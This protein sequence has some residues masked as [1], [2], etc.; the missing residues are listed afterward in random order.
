MEKKI[1]DFITD[2]FVCSCRSCENIVIFLDYSSSCSKLIILPLVLFLISQVHGER[3]QDVWNSLHS[4]QT[5]SQSEKFLKAT[6]EKYE[7]IW[8]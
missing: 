1:Q 2:Y 8:T 4:H 7:A 3:M 5:R 6:D